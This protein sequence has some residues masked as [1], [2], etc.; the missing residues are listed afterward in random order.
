M[1]LEELRSFLAVV[2]S[3][4]FLSAA[5]SLGVSRTTL[6]RRVGALEARAGVPLLET[7]QSGVFVTEA[8]NLLAAKGKLMVQ[9]ASALLSSIREV[10]KEPS[11]VLRVVMPVGLPPHIITPIFASLRAAYPRLTLDLRFSNDPL[12]EP[13]VDIDI[14]VHFSVDAPKGPWI[15]YVVLRVP[16]RLIASEA[17]IARR[18]APRTVDDLEGHELFAWQSPGEDAC[19]WPTLKGGHFRVKPTLVASDVHFIRRCC[20]SG[21]GIGFVPDAMVADP[22]VPAGTLVPV[23]P[24]I[25]GRERP[26]RVT[27]PEALSDIPKIKMVLDRVRAFLGK[28]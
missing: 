23:L 2:E 16:E 26:I 7:S 8:G 4:S 22:G 9:E 25:V 6:R 13:L 17:Y 19:V 11:G 10:G 1:D 5:D 18:G 20:I 27:V 14:A 21:L 28:L 15:S 3:G 24:D 12:G